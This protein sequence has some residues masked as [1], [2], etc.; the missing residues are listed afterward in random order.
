MDQ[1][2]NRP[3]TTE[4]LD[5]AGPQRRD[6]ADI[7]DIV[8]LALPKVLWLTLAA[9]VVFAGLIG[10]A[11]LYLPTEQTFSHAIELSFLNSE[12]REY[13][14][15]TPF[16]L[17]DVVAPAVLKS[18]YTAN[19]LE[20][21]GISLGDFASSVSIKQYAPTLDEV[22]DRFRAQL[23]DRKLTLAE[24]TKIEEDMRREIDNLSRQGAIIT[25]IV[26]S[27]V[28]ISRPLGEKVLAD[29]AQFWAVDSVE[30]RG[31]LKLPESLD[32]ASLI[33]SKVA[34]TLDYGLLV[35]LIE[36]SSGLLKKRI[37]RIKG[38]PGAVTL[39]DGETGVNILSLERQVS[40]LDEFL[41][42]QI[43]AQIAEFGIS[44]DKQFSPLALT[45][46]IGQLERDR[47]R[48]DNERAAV[49][50]MRENFRSQAVNQAATGSRTEMPGGGTVIPQ[51]S[52]DF[53]D[54]LLSLRDNKSDA[55]YAQKLASE[56]LELERKLVATMHLIGT[57]KRNRDA[58]GKQTGEAEIIERTLQGRLS[59]AIDQINA[60]WSTAGRIYQQVNESKF[61]LV[62]SLYR[63]VALPHAQRVRH[64]VERTMTLAVLVAALSALAALLLAAFVARSL[65]VERTRKPSA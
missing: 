31:V 19:N 42:Q 43:G 20:D 30:R 7:V 60:H 28:P 5:A 53:I 56:E 12:R 64:P 54:R 48:L 11:R 55:E 59:Q 23:S 52:A 45:A 46:R 33:D 24:R 13:P 32:Q 29:I 40:V 47:A 18:A 8:R 35:E 51:L 1:L 22:V 2:S 65:L 62:G 3:A 44:R 58:I 6:R 38:F 50:R 16:A 34:A 26:K 37:E 61:A 17:S 41:I 25:M 14:N 9:G 4:P 36:K 63:D 10:V 27:R 39:T 21:H 57:L 15:G 49:Q